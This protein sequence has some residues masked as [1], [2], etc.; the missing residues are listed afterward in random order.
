MQPVNNFQIIVAK[1]VIYFTDE[2]LAS[3]SLLWQLKITKS[4]QSVDAC[5]LVICLM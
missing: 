4:V 3:L 1:F 5:I 2:R